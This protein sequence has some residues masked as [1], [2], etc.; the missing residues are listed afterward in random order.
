MFN[1]MVLTIKE[2]FRSKATGF[3]FFFSVIVLSMLHFF[4][5]FSVAEQGKFVLDIGFGATTFFALILSVY[6][7]SHLVSNDL[8]T[9]RISII[10]I[11]LKHRAHYII[12]R[13]L[14]LAVLVFLA[15]LL[16]GLVFGGSLMLHEWIITKQQ[17]STSLDLIKS[18][19]ILSEQTSTGIGSVMMGLWSVYLQ[20]IVVGAMAFLLS[21]CFNA[22]IAIVL[23]IILY[24][25]G[26]IHVYLVILGFKVAMILGFLLKIVFIFLPRMEF[27][28]IYDAIALQQPITHGYIGW[29]SLYALMAC[30]L[31]LTLS[32]LVFYRKEIT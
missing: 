13:F 17:S 21:I 20:S 4:A 32:S 23:T 16:M 8:N 9:Q 26:Q 2:I 15:V 31:Y 11:S 25:L 7:A 6:F 24:V 12:G 1:I 19:S 10:L 14:G 28:N 18:Y 27:F 3:L 22:N 30:I 5:G 29:I